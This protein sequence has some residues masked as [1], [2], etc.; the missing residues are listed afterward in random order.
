MS[1]IQ[2][3]FEKSKDFNEFLLMYTTHFSEALKQLEKMDFSP[4]VDLILNCRDQSKKL[5]FMGNGGS[6]ANA[7]HISTGLSYVTRHW[8]KPLKSMSLCSDPVLMSSLS[9]DFSYKE[10]FY[11]QLLV[12]LNEGDVVI[13]LSV[14]GNSEN[15]IRAVEYAKEMKATTVAFLGSDG[16][17]L[18]PM[19]D[20]PFHI[21][22]KECLLGLTEDV[23]MLIGHA[24]G[25]YLE[26]KL[27]ELS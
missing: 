13:A 23:H 12:H 4:L 9:N 8:I 10:V 1:I 22:D 27:K 6:A 15:I 7:I 16:G 19:V 20:L 3:S 11:R 14:S 5:I 21:G 2:S 18:K 25:Y 24:L 17:K 26:H